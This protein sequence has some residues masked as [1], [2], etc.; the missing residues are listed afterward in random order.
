MKRE[1]ESGLLLAGANGRMELP[2][3]EKG[4]SRGTVLGGNQELY[5]GHVA[6][7]IRHSSETLKGLWISESEFQERVLGWR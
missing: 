4:K 3:L 5:S 1:E 6:I 7:S 2:L